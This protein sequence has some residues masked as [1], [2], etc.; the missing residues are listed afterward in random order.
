[1]LERR[2]AFLYSL[3][4]K[5]V[6]SETRGKHGVH[7]EWYERDDEREP[8]EATRLHALHSKTYGTYLQ[9]YHVLSRLLD[10]ETDTDAVIDAREDDCYTTGQ[11]T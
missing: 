10:G 2:S 1:M 7:S 3:W 4:L 5:L 6:Y 9:L 11:I 8:L